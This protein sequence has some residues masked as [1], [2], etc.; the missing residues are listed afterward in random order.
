[1]RNEKLCEGEESITFW[2]VAG[3][4]LSRKGENQSPKAGV[5]VLAKFLCIQG[6]EAVQKLVKEL[7]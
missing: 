2:R 6:E 4:F 7:Q 3:G 5:L 1:V